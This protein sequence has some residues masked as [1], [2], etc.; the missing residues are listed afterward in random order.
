[1]LINV[2]VT[3]YIQ[4]TYIDNNLF[5][6]TK[7]DFFECFFQPQYNPTINVLIFIII[8]FYLQI[9]NNHYA[10][11]KYVFHEIPLTILRFG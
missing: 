5:F 11:N 4:T 3:Q 9:L 2:P 10:W 6:K 7:H 1:M 8:Y